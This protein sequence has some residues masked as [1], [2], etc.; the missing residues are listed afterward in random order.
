[1]SNNKKYRLIILEN[2]ISQDHLSWVESCEKR[3]SEIEYSLLDLSRNDW[4]EQVLSQDADYY[5]TNVPSFTTSLKQMYDERLYIIN[6]ILNLPIYPSYEEFLIYENKRM[7]SY[8]LES[9]KV[10]HPRTWIFYNKKEAEYFSE[11]CKYPVVAK[12]TIGASGSGVKI[13]K[14]KREVN[15]YLGDVFTRKGITRYWGINLRK[16]DWGK[17]VFNRLKNLPE[18]FNY[19]AKKRVMATIEPQKLHVIF[20]DYIKCDFEWRCVRIGDSYFGHK[21]LAKRGEKKSGTSEVSWDPPTF[22]LLDFIKT[23][24]EKGNFLSM[25]V[26]VFEPQPGK[27]YVNEMQ[28]F[29]G[30]KNPHQM[31]IDGNPGRYVFKKGA[32]VFEEGLYNTNNSYDLR[33]GHVI[34]LL[35]VK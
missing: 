17:R 35:K 16:G 1:M 13:L 30:S 20:Q 29:W 10:P 9:N 19:M 12:T 33:L 24:T 18:F 25:A 22:Q 6:K 11:Y 32:W 4:L 21:K 8:W 15:K 7:L 14:N 5:L 26:D 34:N 31:L 27:F 23:I 2:G 3:N 28:C